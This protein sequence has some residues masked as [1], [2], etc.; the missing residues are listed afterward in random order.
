MRLI[1]VIA[2]CIPDC[3]NGTCDMTVGECVC[4]DGYIGS[5]CSIGSYIPSGAHEPPVR[6]AHGLLIP[7]RT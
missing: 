5:D 6:A 7:Y 3:V 2:D 1:P 4:D